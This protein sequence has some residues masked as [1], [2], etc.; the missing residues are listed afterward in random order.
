MLYLP[1]IKIILIRFLTPFMVLTFMMPGLLAQ[2]NDG[3]RLKEAENLVLEF[4]IDLN[5]GDFNL[6]EIDKIIHKYFDV[7][8]IIRFVAGPY[9]RTTTNEQ[10]EDYR[11]LFNQFLIFQAKEQFLRLRTLEFTPTKTTARGKRI[12]V[13][14]GITHD[15]MGQYPDAEIKWRLA[16]SPNKPQKII[17]LEVEN[18]SMLKTYRDE[19]ISIVRKNGGDFSALIQALEIQLKRFQTKTEAAN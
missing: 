4:F 9:W 18:I 7:E 6:S 13:V 16:A 5:T 3:V 1:T 11:K 2:P 15:N 12:I 17:D 14:K 19:H 10:R 8:G